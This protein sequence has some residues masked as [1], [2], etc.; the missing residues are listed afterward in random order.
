MR[1]RRSSRVDEA[2]AQGQAC[3]ELLHDYSKSL[4]VAAWGRQWLAEREGRWT[5]RS[6]KDTR[7][8][9]DGHIFCSGLATITLTFRDATRCPEVDTKVDQLRGRLCPMD[10]DI[11]CRCLD[12]TSCA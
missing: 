1:R 4:A 12:S 9:W 5:Q 6:I 10:R 2:R 8:L 3:F 11:R 7:A